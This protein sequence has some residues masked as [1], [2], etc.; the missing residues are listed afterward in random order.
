MGIKLTKLFGF[1]TIIITVSLTVSTYTR[2]GQVRQR[3][4]LKLA[5]PGQKEAQGRKVNRKYSWRLT[6]EEILLQLEHRRGKQPSG[7]YAINPFKRGDKLRLLIPGGE[8]PAWSPTRKFFAYLRDEWLCVVRSDG[9]EEGKIAYSLADSEYYFLDPTVIWGWNDEYA[10]VERNLAFGS[11]VLVGHGTA[12]Y[13]MDPESSP[14]P[15]PGT[16][17][18]PLSKPTSLTGEREPIMWTDLMNTNNPT[19]SPDGKY[20]AM[21]VYPGPMD[22]KRGQSRI[23]IYEFLTDEPDTE[24]WWF[25]LARCFKGKGRRLTSLTGDECELMPLWS[26]TGEWIAFTLVN[27]KEGF[28]AP[29]VVRPDGSDMTMLLPKDRFWPSNKWVPIGVWLTEAWRRYATSPYDWGDP[30]I[31]PVEWSPDGKYLLLN[32]GERFSS[33]IVAKWEGGKWYWR[34]AWG[35]LSQV[36]FATWGP[37]GPWFAYIAGKRPS[38][39]GDCIELINVETLEHI[40]LPLDPNLAVK[41]MDW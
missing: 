37:K 25:L 34:G 24:E 32:E 15:E 38:E 14:T 5:A 30:H 2:S 9:S 41:Y 7:I 6:G 20:M 23:L 27:L 31:T 22:L 39:E 19:F 13:Y 1:I 21:E 10:V 28:V 11:K 12:E 29:V 35:V 40:L 16:F 33:L 36:R 8:R 17:V 26:P 4:S 18:I 3:Y